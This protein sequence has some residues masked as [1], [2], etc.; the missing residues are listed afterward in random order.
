MKT[1]RT[2]PL[3]SRLLLLASL[4]VLAVGLAP[5]RAQVA[6]AP[7]P[8]ASTLAKYDANKNGV[9]EA[10]EVAAIEAAYKAS[11][12]AATMSAE[13]VSLSPFEVVS[14]N[15]GYYAANSM[16]GT[17]FNTRLDDLASSITVLTKEQMADFAMLDFNDMA[18]YTGNAE[19]TGTYTDT[20]VDRNGSVSD[21]VQ[22][23]PNG[24]N[25]VRGIGA[26][27]VSLGNIETMNRVPIDP[28][29]IEGIEVN[30]GPNAN[31]FGLGSPSGTVNQVPASANMTRNKAQVGFRTDSYGGYRESIDVNRMLVQD[32]LAIRVS[33]V[34]QHDGFIRKPSGL[35]TQRFNGMV[36]FRPF[37][38]TTI[39]SS[40]NYYRMIGNRAN[41][42]P[43]RDN[44]SYWN[45]SGRPTWDPITQQIH[46]NGV[47]VG[48]YPAATY[49]G[50]DYF[51][52]T[53][54][55]GTYNQMFIDQGGLG[56]W[57]APQGTTN[58]VPLAGATTAGPTSGGVAARFLMTTGI[59]GATGTAA[60]PVAQPL[61]TTTP[62]VN[63][64]SLY[65]WSSINTA[66]VNHLVDRTDTINFHVDQLFLN[67]PRHV[68][69]AQA[70]FMREDSGRYA[71]NLLGA[72][73]D[74]G[75]SGQ[76][77]IDINERLLDGTPNPYFLR[78]FLASGK[79][80]TVISPAKWDTYRLQAAY[81]LDLTREPG[82]LKWLGMHQITGY[83]EYKYRVNR[84]YS[85]RDVITDSKSWIPPGLYRAN[86]A[87]V[88][89]TP[90]LIALTQ[91][92]YRYYVG[93]KTGDNIDYAPY[94]FKYG[95]YPFVW[96][97]TVT[98][99]INREPTT[100]GIGATTDSSGGTNNTKQITKTLGS[101]IQSHFLNERFI[102]TFGLREDKVYSRFGNRATA[103][104]NPD[105]LT[106]N[107]ALINSWEPGDWGFN[108]GKT[109]NVQFVV[110]PFREAGFL[111][112]LNRS[113]SGGHFAASALGG[114]SVHYNRSNSF[115]P[116]TPAQ[117]LFLNLLPNPTGED[118]SFGMGL[119]LFDG[120]V[121]VR[122]TRYETSQLNIR[123]GDA[124][125]TAQRVIR[126]DLLLQGATPARF[127]LQ[128]IA[129]GTTPTFGPNNDQFGWIKTTNP[130]WTNQQV[131]DEFVKVSGLS[132]ATINA[133]LIPTPPIAATNDIVAKGTEVEINLNLT[134][135]WTVAANFADTQAT[136]RNVSP[137][138]QKW[139]DQRMPIW[140][141]LKDP[142]IDRTVE[143]QQLWWNHNYGGTET[144]QQ[145]FVNFV[146]T[147]YSVIKQLE[148]QANPQTRR[149]TFKAST[150]FRLSG[151]T[152]HQILRRFNVGGA[153]RWEDKG[154]IGFY[155]KQTLPARI[156]DLDVSRPIWDSAHTYFDGFVSYK[157]KIWNNKIG[158]TLQLNAQNI[159]EDGR[160][161]KIGAY[162]DGTP[163]NFR[164]VDPRKFILQATFDL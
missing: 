131:F 17:R 23:N 105:G 7:A 120:K 108:S 33:Q 13:V 38:S 99:A 161:Q 67:T 144:A 109:T 117:D 104:L 126:T 160:L 97:N 15:K 61:F 21:N 4:G 107:E 60:K 132:A 75:Q 63:N 145:N 101:V 77:E 9:L 36:K 82:A 5:S 129:G 148:G 76:L 14:D 51:S 130:T 119:N 12:T 58:T 43:P 55:G 22:L 123:N 42:L 84:Q 45:R 47:T 80:R 32:K 136:V 154:A 3:C 56:Y 152:E 89:G 96:G 164:I 37:K 138:L 121:V 86:Q 103:L 64:K 122:V 91:G 118:K 65:D 150:N 147:P 88:A 50:P 46:L 26:A 1:T 35:N 72:A 87:A 149:Y 139:I 151:I 114:L 24:A 102:T 156:T 2:L 34:F 159:F 39:S 70:S 10:N 141:T 112:D 40:Y 115:I 71:R 133:L 153:I 52:A 48:T 11:S 127:V 163:N 146:A 79:P 124:N 113:G 110:R 98:G 59:E 100:L 29:S 30:R 68:L 69:A 155:G 78:P 74:N 44:I 19:G 53:L 143:P 57:S 66:S 157:M 25:R 20:V 92:L 83:N 128:N 106:F 41:S 28:I 137:A 95:T 116:A 31:V 162:P 90:A 111:N 135:Y 125:T 134:P 18:L 140:T 49:N 73:N 16:S 81:R 8:D 27:N 6:P 62:A 142:T 158:T 94:D 93:D 85:Y 54:I